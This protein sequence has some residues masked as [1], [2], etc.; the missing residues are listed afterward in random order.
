MKLSNIHNRNLPIFLVSDIF[1]GF[2]NEQKVAEICYYL[3]HDRASE[4]PGSIPGY[5]S[6]TNLHRINSL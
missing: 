6:Q 2:K 4:G 1:K 3:C 5:T